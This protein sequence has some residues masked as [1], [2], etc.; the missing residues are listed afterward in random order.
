[1]L[2][3]SIC[4]Y[5]T[6]FA[7]L[8]SV[9][10]LAAETGKFYVSSSLGNDS[11]SGSISSPLKTFAK[12]PRESA[13]I[14]LKRG[15]VFT[16]PLHNIK[17]CLI[18]AYGEGPKPI[19]CGFKHL[20]NKDAWESLGEGIWRLDLSKSEN[21]DGYNSPE[22]SR[23]AIFNN[24]GAIHDAATNTLHG[25]KVKKMSEMKSD[26]DFFQSE[27][28][29]SKDVSMETFRYIYVKLPHSP[30]LN[31][32]LNFI[33]Y[34]IGIQ[35]AK[36]CKIQN[37]AVRGFGRHGI[38]G[39][40]NSTVEN[41]DIDAIGGSVQIGYKRWVRLGNG[42]EFW[43]SDGA[44]GNNST[45]KNCTISRTY[46][47]GATIQGIGKKLPNP[48]SIKFL[49]NRFYHCRQAFEHFL[50]SEIPADY[51]DCEFSGNI[52]FEMG[53]NE[54]SSPEPRDMNLLSYET[55]SKSIKISGNIFYGGGIYFGVAWSNNIS[56]NT[57]Y[58]FEDNF[59]ASS[60][61]PQKIPPIP[62]DDIEA[63][64]RRFNDSTSKI[65]VIKRGEREIRDKL[66]FN[67]ELC[68]KP[69]QNDAK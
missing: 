11:N 46:D 59:L 15:D 39:L 37:I 65:V 35:N 10:A 61:Q 16:E 52:A 53:N 45:V 22:E 24:I 5:F 29:S 48:K 8:V 42:I 56:N 14:Y 25:H 60:Y 33:P 50:T 68:K 47:C 64:R 55:T 13:E 3:K 7:A 40:V 4:V 58:V 63:Y 57:C 23:K 41:V 12:I 1:M 34:Q 30:S 66:K 44:S 19:I 54:F 20:K 27:T 6:I 21:F 38:T 31:A 2:K 17:N 26:W 36:N 69:S 28:F 51:I 32:D 49:N 9:S 62:S 18:D 67:V 43:V